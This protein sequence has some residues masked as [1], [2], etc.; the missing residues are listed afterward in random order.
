MIAEKI[1]A[2]ALWDTIR[3]DRQLVE[4]R[5]VPRVYRQARLLSGEL[6][7]FAKEQ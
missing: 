6:C 2:F 5:G 7:I 3:P 1:G 4:M